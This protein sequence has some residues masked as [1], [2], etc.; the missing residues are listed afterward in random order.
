MK[1][2]EKVGHSIKSLQ[3]FK[4][5][6]KQKI[7]RKLSERF[8]ILLKSYRTQIKGSKQEKNVGNSVKGLTFN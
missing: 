6:L 7:R 1:S 8:E 5:K 3:N 2:S 4:K